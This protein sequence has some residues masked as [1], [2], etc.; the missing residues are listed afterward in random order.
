MH[1]SHQEPDNAQGLHATTPGETTECDSRPFVKDFAGVEGKWDALS[2]RLM[3]CNGVSGGVDFSGSLLLGEERAKDG[4]RSWARSGVW[5]RL[6]F[7][8]ELA[9]SHGISGAEG[10]LTTRNDSAKWSSMNLCNG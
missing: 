4:T 2:A 1:L 7:R 9:L 5:G 3:N 6:V 8:N 10:G